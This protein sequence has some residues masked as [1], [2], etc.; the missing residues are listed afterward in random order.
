MNACPPG[1]YQATWE[2]NWFNKT[3]IVECEKCE[4]TKKERN[5]LKQGQ[6]VVEKCFSRGD[7]IC[8]AS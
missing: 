7:D 4:D 1:T 5:N 2:Y 6:G 3:I 8:A